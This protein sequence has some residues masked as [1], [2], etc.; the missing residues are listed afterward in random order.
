LSARQN[1]IH[2]EWLQLVFGCPVS[3]PQKDRDWTGPRPEKTGN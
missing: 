1:R 2:P 3:K